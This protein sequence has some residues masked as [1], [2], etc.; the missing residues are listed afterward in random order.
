MFSTYSWV[1]LLKTPSSYINNMSYHL[2]IKIFARNIAIF[3]GYLLVAGGLVDSKKTSNLKVSLLQIG[4]QTQAAYAIFNGYLLWASPADR[5]VHISHLP[6][7][8]FLVNG[9]IVLFILCGIMLYG[10]L[11][12]GYFAR[13]LAW[14]LVIVTVFVDFDTRY[15]K[16]RGV[17]FW[18]QIHLGTQNVCAIANLILI[19]RVQNWQNVCKF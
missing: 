13:L 14:M 2:Q 10:G 18:D 15:W 4:R 9:L 6:L 8:W 5:M 3:G 16:I 1:A 11:H 19:G 17:S 7:G 12:A